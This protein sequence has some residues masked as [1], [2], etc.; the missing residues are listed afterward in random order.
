MGL[1]KGRFL[2]SSSPDWQDHIRQSYIDLDY[3][4]EGGESHS[5][6]RF[7]ASQALENMQALGGHRPAFVTHG[8]LTAALFSGIDPDFGFADWKALRNPDLFEVEIDAG[9]VLAFERLEMERSL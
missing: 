3:A 6:L 5:D 2:Q 1:R 8:G 7:R 4:P 9:Q